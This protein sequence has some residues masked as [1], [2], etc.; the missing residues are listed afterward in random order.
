MAN[1]SDNR[2]GRRSRDGDPSVTPLSGPM[3]TCAV[4]GA[5]YPRGQSC[6][7]CR[8]A[9]VSAGAGGVDKGKWTLIVVLVAL[10]GGLMV[11]AYFVV[12]GMAHTGEQ[13]GRALQSAQK[14][15]TG[16]S[17]AVQLAV[18]HKSL[19]IAAE[20]AD[21]KFPRALTELY[22]ARELHCP[23]NEEVPYVY[24]PGQDQSMPGDNVLV[25]EPRATH[26]GRCSV[27]RLNGKV[28][29]LPT[30]DLAAE[31]DKTRAVIAAAKRGP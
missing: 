16:V 25:Y 29:M 22:S 24:V 8:R 10:F 1:P 7:R 14:R 4:C 27:L 2:S 9:Q 15:G 21:G 6:P 3:N 17:C 20:S 13:Y 26:D 18:I 23:A 19:Q 5:S 11:G 28:E 30:Q 12:K 31:L